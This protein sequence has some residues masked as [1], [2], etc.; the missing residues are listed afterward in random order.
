MN[1]LEKQLQSW[2]PRRPSS[3]VAR[4]LFGVTGEASV[5]PRRAASWNWLA[6]MAACALT[7]LVAVHTASLATPPRADRSNSGSLFTFILNAAATSSNLATFSLSQMD[8]NMEWNIWSHASHHLALAPRAET[9]P[10][11]DLFNVILTNR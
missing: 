4:R 9:R 3:R 10:R 6:P 2:V 8:E 7:M 11:L 5:T 1:Q